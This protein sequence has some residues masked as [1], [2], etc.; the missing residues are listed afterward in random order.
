MV[1]RLTVKQERLERKV[2]IQSQGGPAAGGS[3]NPR[4]E[5]AAAAL[6]WVLIEGTAGL[7]LVGAAGS[8]EEEAEDLGSAAAEVR[9]MTMAGWV[10]SWA[11]AAMEVVG[12]S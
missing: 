3:C 2:T 11:A 10:G 4:G 1:G 6:G 9:A 12:S 7:D 5:P 8:D